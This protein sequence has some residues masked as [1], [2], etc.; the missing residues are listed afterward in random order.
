MNASL[1]A[2]KTEGDDQDALLPDF[3]PDDIKQFDE[4]ANGKISCTFEECLN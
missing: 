3:K 1:N 2:V 4:F